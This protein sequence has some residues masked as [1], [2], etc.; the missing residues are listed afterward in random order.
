MTGVM[1]SVSRVSKHDGCVH[2]FMS[3]TD[4]CCAWSFLG[5][6]PQGSIR[7]CIIRRA[8]RTL[9]Q[10][11]RWYTDSSSSAQQR[12]TRIV[13]LYVVSYIRYHTNDISTAVRPVYT[14]NTILF[15]PYIII[16]VTKAECLPYSVLNSLP[17]IAARVYTAV[18]EVHPCP[19]GPVHTYYVAAVMVISTVTNNAPQI[20]RS[21]CIE[22]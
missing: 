10:Q 13:E 21:E 4:C 19:V 17:P 7:W 6:V 20:T 9:E 14:H 1:V 11:C 8:V 15:S 2:K 18:A 5:L 16:G 3:R 22:H 12:A